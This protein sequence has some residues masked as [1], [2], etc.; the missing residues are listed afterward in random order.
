MSENFNTIQL[1]GQKG[2]R[3]SF[4]DFQA[5]PKLYLV[6]LEVLTTDKVSTYVY[7]II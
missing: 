1:C 7:L 6:L 5:S 2:F 3:L 4:A